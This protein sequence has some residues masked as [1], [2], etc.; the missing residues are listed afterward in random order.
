MYLT[1]ETSHFERLHQRIIYRAAGSRSKGE[2]RAKGGAFIFTIGFNF[3]CHAIH[4]IQDTVE[5]IPSF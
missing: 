5:N 1:T 3:I 4:Q 2:Y